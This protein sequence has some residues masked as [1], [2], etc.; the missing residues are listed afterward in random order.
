MWCGVRPPTR[1]SPTAL[2][3][4]KISK[5]TILQ[6]FLTL[7][8]AD[9]VDFCIFIPIELPTMDPQNDGK[10]NFCSEAPEFSVF[11]SGVSSLVVVLP[12]LPVLTHLF[13]FRER[14]GRRDNLRIA[15]SVGAGA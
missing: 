9:V 2:S 4:I 15:R 7:D 6:E 12:L 10:F 3:T 14:E 8:L 11:Q 5:M 13:C 1:P